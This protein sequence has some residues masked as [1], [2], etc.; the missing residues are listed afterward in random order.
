MS[1]KFFKFEFEILCGLRVLISTSLVFLLAY[2]KDFRL[3]LFFAI[4]IVMLLS[5]LIFVYLDKW[6]LMYIG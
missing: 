4:S 6:T 3:F 2:E 1:L 5:D